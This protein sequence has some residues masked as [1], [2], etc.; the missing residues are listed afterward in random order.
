MINNYSLDSTVNV[1]RLLK[2]N[3]LRLNANPQ[4]PVGL[5]NSA[6]NTSLITQSGITDEEFFAQF[7]ASTANPIPVTEGGGLYNPDSAA[8]GILEIDDYEATL[9]DLRNLM[10]QRTQGLSAFARGP[11]QSLVDRIL[12]GFQPQEEG[13]VRE[14]W[15]IVPIKPDPL[16]VN[17]YVTAILNTVADHS[18]APVVPSPISG[19]RAPSGATAPK[20]GSASFDNLVAELMTRLGV[21]V[22]EIMEETIRGDGINPKAITAHEVVPKRV[23]QLLLLAYYRDKPW[24]DSGVNLVVWET[25]FNNA[26]Y[27]YTAWLKRYSVSYLEDVSTG[28]LL[29]GYNTAQR[30]VYVLDPV[31]EDFFRSGGTAE[32]I[33]GLIYAREDGEINIIATVPNVLENQ[34]RLVEIWEARSLVRRQESR[35]NWRDIN[36]R[37]LKSAVAAALEI[38]D[39]EELGLNSSRSLLNV[40]NEVFDAVDALFKRVGNEDLDLT[41]EVITLAGLAMN[42]ALGADMLLHVHRAIRE[43]GKPE[44]AAL[45]WTAEYILSYLLDG[46][47]VT[48]IAK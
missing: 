15:N 22:K 46:V 39:A 14:T 32:A 41:A 9:V 27:D 5:L 12:K 3:G 4:T 47:D 29:W 13:E 20:T 23:L 24:E 43:G 48:A 35:D 45:D 28:L 40:R 19:L 37:A 38:T 7:A 10:I 34:G 18:R 8:M 21:T 42:E 36:Q 17:D 11:M 1:M 31:L 44:D 25:I 30:T 16:L 2:T 33:Y 26:I 6:T